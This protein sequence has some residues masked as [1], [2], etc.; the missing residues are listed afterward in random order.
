M[1]LHINTKHTLQAFFIFSHIIFVMLTYN[2]SHV[3]SVLLDAN[4]KKKIDH[5]YI[6]F[7]NR[8]CY[9]DPRDIVFY[10]AA[11]NARWLKGFED[12]KRLARYYIVFQRK[13]AFA[14]FIVNKN[15]IEIF[16]VPD[17]KFEKYVSSITAA[18]KVRNS[19]LHYLSDNNVPF[20][21]IN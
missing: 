1:E 18:R 2:I 17:K 16:D 6:D 5:I 11:E 14:D 12:E 4:K 3:D 13:K 20:R 15:I 7:S 8:R 21:L 10:F 19:F 9:V